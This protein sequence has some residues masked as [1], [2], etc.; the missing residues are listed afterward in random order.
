MNILSKRLLLY[1][2]VVLLAYVVILLYVVLP[3]IKKNNLERSTLKAEKASFNYIL[4][5]SA[6]INKLKKEEVLSNL[7]KV[8]GSRQKSG[9]FFKFL[10]TSMAY[11]GIASSKPLIKAAK[12]GGKR[13][14]ILSLKGISLNKAIDVIYLISNSGYD[15]AF[16]SLKLKRNFNNRGLLDL[17]ADFKTA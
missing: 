8:R 5:Y 2:G 7:N 17:E 9:G 10:N 13:E 14:I 3:L 4:L 6:K 1:A 16:K 12:S 11:F 15:T